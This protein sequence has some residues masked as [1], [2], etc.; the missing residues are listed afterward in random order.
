MRA[1]QLWGC[2][3]NET[4]AAVD[5][6]EADFR[7]VMRSLGV[8]VL[9]RGDLAEHDNKLLYSLKMQT[10]VGLDSGDEGDDR[11]WPNVEHI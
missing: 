4:L 8:W 9:A 5:K 2:K 10:S 3:C 1:C 11:S 6:L 7:G